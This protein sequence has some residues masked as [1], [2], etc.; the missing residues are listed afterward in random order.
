MNILMMTNT[1]SPHVGGVARSIEA[2]SKEYR[3]RGH[4]VLVITPTFENTPANENDVIRIPAIQHF[5]GSDF[6]VALPIPRLVTSAVNEFKA[7]I[8]HSHHPFLIGATALRVAYTHELPLVYTHH[9][10]YEDYTHYLPGDSETLKRFVIKLSTNYAN[11]CDLIFAPSESIADLIKKR[12]VETPISVVPTGVDTKQRQDTNGCQ[13]R[14]SLG[15]PDDAFVVGH[16]GRLAAE[17]NLDFLAKAII[18]FI[19]NNTHD[20]KSCFLLIGVGAMKNEV[21]NLF[22]RTDVDDRLFTAGVLTKSQLDSAYR[23]MDVFAFASKSETQ[24]MVITE[25]M[26][27]GVPVVALDA[28]GVREVVRD[29][30]NGRLLL[31]EDLETF[32]S[33]LTWT[34]TRA[35]HER[36]QLMQNALETAEEFSIQRCAEKALEQFRQLQQRKLLQRHHEF[37]VWTS[38]LKLIESEWAILRGIANAAGT[39]LREPKE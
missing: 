21:E 8:V 34:Y 23:A 25:A 13:F 20:R 28:P 9:T 1:F 35:H 3:S 27:A 17:K 37:N 11:L 15:I 7:D 6:S 36:K 31:T 4:R 32:A 22:A 39:A 5:N 10:K 18:K 38:T 12:G 30:Q 2:F 19:E 29:K 26:A 16:L 14:Q 24:G 33:A